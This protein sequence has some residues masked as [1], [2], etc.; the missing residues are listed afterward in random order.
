LRQAK[1]AGATWDALQAWCNA[2]G[3]WVGGPK[4]PVF[5]AVRK[6][7]CGADGV[8][9]TA[10]QPLTTRSLARILQERAQGVLPAEVVAHLH[11]HGLRH[12]FATLALEA[13]AS[14]RRVQYAMGHSDPRTT[15][16]YDRARENLADNAA[17]YVSKV[18]NG[19]GITET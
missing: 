5:V 17:D 16:R 10:E 11:P 12:A 8:L 18:L 4:A 13:G 19:T 15:E 1:L 14:L 6:I 2:A 3:R 7:G 9:V